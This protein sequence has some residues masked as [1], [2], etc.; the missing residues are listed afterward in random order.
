MP[1]DPGHSN[2]CGALKC[3]PS[4]AF[5]AMGSLFPR[6]VEHRISTDSQKKILTT[7]DH[8]STHSIVLQIIITVFNDP[9]TKNVS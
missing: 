6:D 7:E 9:S 4:E 1:L 8:T 5:A 3:S 2:Q